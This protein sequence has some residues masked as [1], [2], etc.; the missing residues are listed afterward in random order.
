MLLERID[1]CLML[2]QKEKNINVEKLILDMFMSLE[3]LYQNIEQ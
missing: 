3:N 2:S 1:K